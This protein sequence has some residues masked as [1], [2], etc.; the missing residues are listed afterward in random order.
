MANRDEVE[1]PMD[2][3]GREI[4]RER[5]ERALHDEARSGLAAHEEEFRLKDARERADSGNLK[6]HPGR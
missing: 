5:H 3:L 6:R 2:R 1:E 4:A